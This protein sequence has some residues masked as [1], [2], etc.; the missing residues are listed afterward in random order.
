MISKHEILTFSK[1]LCLILYLFILYSPFLIILCSIQFFFIYLLFLLS[2]FLHYFL[3]PFCPSYYPQFSFLLYFPI[4]KFTSLLCDYFF[5]SSIF[6]SFFW[7]FFSPSSNTSVASGYV[8]EIT[9]ISFNSPI[10]KIFRI[11]D[12][13]FFSFKSA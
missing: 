2:F 10:Y 13:T 3:P 5:F 9:Y 11:H 12:K 4:L 8:S 7:F 6:L 1:Y